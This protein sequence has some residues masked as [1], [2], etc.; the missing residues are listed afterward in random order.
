[1]VS[2]REIHRKGSKVV[3]IFWHFS[4]GQYNIDLNCPYNKSTNIDW[5][6]RRNP[7]HCLRDFT[8]SFFFD[9]SFSTSGLLITLFKS[10]CKPSRR[11]LRNSWVSCCAWPSNYIQLFYYFYQIT[12]GW[13]L[14]IALLKFEG[15][16]TEFSPYHICL[17]KLANS[18]ARIP[19][20]PIGLLVLISLKWW[21]LRK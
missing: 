15:D 19:F 6:R 17:S 4:L 5:L 21:F 1:M 16:T 13:N 8:S 20:V 18:L 2:G 7:Y 3:E 9:S 11:K 14:A 10:S 12:I